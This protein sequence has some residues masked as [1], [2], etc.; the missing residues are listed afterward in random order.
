VEWAEIA[1]EHATEVFT[2]F[3]EK[4][5]SAEAVARRVA[6][7]ALAWLAAEVPVGEHAADQLLLP[8]ALAGGGRFRTTEPSLHA[9][10]QAEVVARFLDARTTFAPDGAG[11]AVSVD[12]G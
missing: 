9:R 7:E 8:M 5:V 3:G 10:T 1:C 12:R 11:W 6:D 2:G 4:G